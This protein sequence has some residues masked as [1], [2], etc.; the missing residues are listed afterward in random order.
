MGGESRPHLFTQR[1][2]VLDAWPRGPNARA[3]RPAAT[4][5]PVP[6]SPPRP[7]GAAHEPQHHRPPPDSEALEHVLTAAGYVET[8]TTDRLLE[9]RCP[10]ARAHNVAAEDRCKPAELANGE[11]PVHS[12]GAASACPLAARKL[13]ELITAGT[14]ARSRS[15]NAGGFRPAPHRLCQPPSRQRSRRHR[16]GGRTSAPDVDEDDPASVASF[17]PSRW[18]S[19]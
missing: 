19:G 5:S 6:T 7:L 3:V 18:L 2:T 10:C 17:Q 11:A 14:L 16:G 13:Y 15:V 1:P 12:G 8:E 9:V 4:R